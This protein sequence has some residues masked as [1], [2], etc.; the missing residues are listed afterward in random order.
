MKQPDFEELSSDFAVSTNI[1]PAVN[2]SN[3]QTYYISDSVAVISSTIGDTILK[4]DDTQ[5]LVDAVK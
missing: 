5:K 2:F 4:N 1:D 3:F